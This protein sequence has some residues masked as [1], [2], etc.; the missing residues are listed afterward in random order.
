[1][2]FTIKVFLTLSVLSSA[3]FAGPTNAAIIWTEDFSTHGA[4]NNPGGNATT[5]GSGMIQTSGNGVVIGSSAT[6]NPNG[7][8]GEVLCFFSDGG[9]E[10]FAVSTGTPGASLTTG[11]FQFDVNWVDAGTGAQPDRTFMQFVDGPTWSTNGTPYPN[12]SNTVGPNNGPLGLLQNNWATV[13]YFFN[14]LGV[15]IE[16]TAPDGSTELLLAGSFDVWNGTTRVGN[17]FMGTGNM[18]PIPGNIDTWAFA[19]F[20]GQ[21]GTKFEFDNMS[22]DMLEHVVVPEPSTTLLSVLGLLSLLGWKRR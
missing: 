18:Q 1:M 10:R 2:N 14:T 4:G 7:G 17:N 9:T 22:M 13:C 11:K 15:D 3:W 5:T 8:D 16:Y 20:N 12:F 21:T 19:M 6:T